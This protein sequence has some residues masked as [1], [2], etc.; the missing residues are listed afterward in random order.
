MSNQIELKE[1]G[2]ISVVVHV[3]EQTDKLADNI[4]QLDTYFKNRF[5]TYEYILVNNSGMSNLDLVGQPQL[6]GGDLS[7]VN[8]SWQ[9]NIENAMSAGIDLAI[10]DFI[11]EFDSHE[12]DYPMELI[13]EVYTKCLSGYDM[14]AAA[15]SI[16]KTQ[17]SRSFYYLLNKLSYKNINLTTETFRIVSRRM[18]NRTNHKNAAFKYRKANYHGSGLQTCLIKYKPREGSRKVK[19]YTFGEQISLAS[20]I[21]IYYSSIGT[22]LSTI[23]SVVFLFVSLLVGG[24]AIFSYII[25]KNEIQE[26]WTTTM[27]FLSV[28]FA[29]FFAILAVLSKYM[30]V[31][32]KATHSVQSYTYESID[33]V[34]LK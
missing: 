25:L 12:I 26:G 29:G 31:L 18:I 11:F 9:H 24:Y 15:P 30:E 22:K 20:N 10:G 14:V 32:L 17:Y 2:F 13:D 19:E 34:N 3:K 28:S 21:L 16:V 4:L 27:L 6:L 1:K 23:L 33:R 7:V 5:E 8:L